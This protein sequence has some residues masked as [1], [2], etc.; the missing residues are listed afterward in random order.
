MDCKVFVKNC[1]RFLDLSKV[2]TGVNRGNQWRFGVQGVQY[3]FCHIQSL[4]CV[5][6]S[7]FLLV[8]SPFE[9]I[10]SLLVVVRVMQPLLR[11]TRKRQSQCPV[12]ILF[13]C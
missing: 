4:C 1:L 5:M 2:L 6:Y 8:L 7:P 10:E 9:F 12:L 13:I 11:I 3:C